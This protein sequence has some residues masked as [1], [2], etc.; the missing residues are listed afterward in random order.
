MK[1]LRVLALVLCAA[2]ALLATCTLVRAQPA[3][4]PHGDAIAG[5]AL[6]AK[7]CVTC[8]VRRMGGDGTLMYTRIDRKVTTTE[9]LQA[10]VA[11]CNAEL[12]TGYFPDEEADVA[13]Y[14]NRSFYKFPP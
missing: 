9:K 4:P 13:A 10:Q 11:V 1:G 3:K 7:D 8:H 2:V 14:L 12:S 6:H 5:A